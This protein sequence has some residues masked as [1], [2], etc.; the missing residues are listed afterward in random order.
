MSGEL[1]PSTT[2]A[3]G[4]ERVCAVGACPRS[5]FY[6]RQKRETQVVVPLQA[7]GLTDSSGAAAGGVDLS[8]D[9]TGEENGR[10]RGEAVKGACGERSER[11]LDGLEHDRTLVAAAGRTQGGAEPASR[12]R[13][14]PKPQLSDEGLLEA[15][16]EEITASPF[17]GEGYR[18]I[19]R[20]LRR[21]PRPIF[22]A[23]KRVLRLMG[24]A[25]LLSP[26]RLPQ[27]PPLLHD[28][29]ITTDEPNLIW[30]TDGARF[31]TVEEGWAWVFVAVEH[32]NAECVGAHVAKKGDR[33]AALEPIAQ[34]LERCLGGAQGGVGKGH[35][36][37]VRSDHGSQYTSEHF[38]NQVAFWGLTQ[39]YAF[40]REPQTNGVAERFIRTLK[41]QV[42]H[43]RAYRNVAEAR[44]A[45]RLFVDRYN[46]DWLVEKNG[47][48]SPLERRRVYEQNAMRLA[49]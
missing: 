49:A 38:G 4:V 32:W 9:P 8:T 36:L 10:A 47:L 7:Q 23:R 34:G 14:G 1:S 35:S 29:R 3:D 33:F 20:R 27:R 41:E 45:V 28:G 12:R 21:R 46:S 5:T 22:V 31:E 25:S 37:R 48:M 16:R 26:H 30:G 17:K 2:R 13:R 24:E 40:V 43:G 11:A 19:W 6:A 42:F 15:I 44:E 18:K 39:S